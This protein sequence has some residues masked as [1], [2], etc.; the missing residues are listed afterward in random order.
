MKEHGHLHHHHHDLHTFCLA[1]VAYNVLVVMAEVVLQIIFTSNSAH[2]T[3]SFEIGVQV[4]HLIGVVILAV[5]QWWIMHKV[6]NQNVQKFFLI[7][8]GMVVIHMILLRLVPRLLGIVLEEHHDN[9]IQ[10]VIVL[11]CIVIFVSVLFWKREKRL[12]KRR[13]K[14]KR[15]WKLW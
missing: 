9:E 7:S 11:V 3:V 1:T 10:E 14:H 13:L 5:L 8:S 6:K 12:T 4:F 2:E 15:T